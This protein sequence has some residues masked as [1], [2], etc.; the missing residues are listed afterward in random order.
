M[1]L[2][3]QQKPDVHEGST[4]TT[5]AVDR[6]APAATAAPPT[7]SAGEAPRSK[8]EVLEALSGL[9]LAMFVSILSATIV[10]NA[11]PT[12]I[13]DLH[14][15]Q[16]QYTW[17]VTATLLTT[18]A[19]TPIWGK[20]ADLFDKK[21][22]V[23][24]AIVIFVVS[25]AMAG[26]AQSMGWLIG[27]RAVQGIGAG[28]L[29][30]LAQVVIAALIPP[31]ERGRY[32]GYLGAVLA[33]ATVSGPLIG[34]LL[35]DTSWLGWRWCFY[36]GVPIG[37]IALIVL[38]RTLHVPTVKRDVQLDYLGATLIAGGVSTL[39][40][41]ISLAGSQFAWGSVT[42]LTLGALGIAALV[43]AVIVEL[44]VPEPVVPMELFRNRTVVLAVLGSIVLGLVM[45]GGSVFLGQYFQ[46]ARGYAP[47]EAGLLTLP[48]VGGLMIASTVSGQL[49][50]R[51]GRW[52]GFLVAGA[53]L[54]TA[55]LALLSTMDHTTSIPFLG[56]YLGVLGLGVGMSMQNLVL[57]V[58][59]TV[60][61]TE[62]GSASS[63]VA[64]LRSM[65]G[66]IGVTV[67]GIVLS[68]RVSALLGVPASGASSG[69]SDLS[70]LDGAAAAAVR[71]AYGDAIG[72]VFLIAA[73]GSI[74]TLV[75]VVFI[76]EVPLRTTVARSPEAAPVATPSVVAQAPA[77]EAVATV[78]VGEAADAVDDPAITFRELPPAGDGHLARHAAADRE[79]FGHRNGQPD[80]SRSGEALAALDDVERAA[81]DLADA[82]GRLATSVDRLRAA[83]FGQ[84]QI[85]G[86]LARRVADGATAG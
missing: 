12:I 81:R 60:D 37:V 19:S 10:S 35:V 64:F 20:L 78:E 56:V 65:G 71:A 66:T 83:G 42:S 23:Q 17:V 14:G 45:F 82:R 54:T 32:S 52:K 46:V 3:H 53:V 36:V 48:L 84:Q 7:A 44:R 34:G 62:I 16:T 72:R 24:I 73:I 58:Q 51:Y 68:H 2:L 43:A 49:I 67:L 27:W 40:I 6:P 76:K 69:T 47:T 39:L 22:L 74:L 28:G 9:L 80:T 86:L 55:G 75:A 11:L 79:R 38:Q 33:T 5:T 15:S 70:Q 63:L 26:L 59:N 21:L 31:R 41:W 61:V 8:R 85:D 29:Q 25:S 4:M 13:A 50:S 30:A 18:T 1:T 77:A 57:A